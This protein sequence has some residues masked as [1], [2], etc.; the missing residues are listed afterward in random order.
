MASTKEITTDGLLQELSKTAFENMIYQMSAMVLESL[1]TLD[2]ERFI[3]KSINFIQNTDENSLRS[4]LEVVWDKIQ[5]Q[6]DR[7]LEWRDSRERS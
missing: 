1:L 3:Q 4:I 5:Q 7:E 2:K 6:N